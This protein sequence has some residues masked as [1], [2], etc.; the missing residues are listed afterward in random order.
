MNLIQQILLLKKDVGR[1]TE[2]NVP[3]FDLGYNQALKDIVE[4]IE[5]KQRTEDDAWMKYL[6]G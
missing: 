1:P 6:Y 4:L 3:L 5:K 2:K